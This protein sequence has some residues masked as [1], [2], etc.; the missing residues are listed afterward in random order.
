MH[1]N[2]ISDPSEDNDKCVLLNHQIPRITYSGGGTNTHSAIL[3]AK[4]IFDATKRKSSKK[5]LILITDGFSNGK[6]PIPIARDL[7]LS[8]VIIFTVGIS[9]GNLKEL[10]SIS[11]KPFSNYN[12]MLSSFAL[13][14]S[15][16]R[17]ALH[18]DYK[19]G[20]ILPVTND[21]LCDSLCDKNGTSTS[22]CDSN[23]QCACGFHSGHYSCICKPGYYGVGLAPHGCEVCPNG[24]YWNF[25]NSCLNCPDINHQTVNSPALTIDECVCKTGFKETHKHRCEMIKCPLLPV[26]D[27]GYFVEGSACLNTVNTACG[28][29]CNSGYQLVGSSIRIC[30]E[31][32]I[33]SG[34]ETECVCE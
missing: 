27:N 16:A 9:S 3:K 23:S 20:V 17:K 7:K 12:Y 5:F 31:D 15:L 4:E 22:C 14:E 29:R 11:S 34:D 19:A 13:F 1:V 25:W 24:T 30:Q 8:G 28:A 32:G 2:Q 10:R 21:S 6:S 18:T 33:W 26:P